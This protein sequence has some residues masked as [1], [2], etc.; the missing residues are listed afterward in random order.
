M[1]STLLVGSH[2]FAG[3]RPAQPPFHSAPEP[4]PAP[5][6][7]PA[8]PRTG[9]AS[10]DAVRNSLAGW[11]IQALITA[12]PAPLHRKMAAALAAPGCAGSMQAARAAARRRDPRSRTPGR[13][14][15]LAATRPHYPPPPPQVFP[16][17]PALRRVCVNTQNC[18]PEIIE[19]E[20]ACRPAHRSAR[21]GPGRLPAQ[22]PSVQGPAL[23][24][25]RAAPPRRATLATL[26]M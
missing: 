24:T 19:N 10:R 6:P 22:Q 8:G 20:F 2:S 13:Y 1:P 7:L 21:R 9:R 25:L 11:A 3:R 14:Q 5:P 23:P 12:R 17:R 18:T 16:P 15:N 26:A 4:R